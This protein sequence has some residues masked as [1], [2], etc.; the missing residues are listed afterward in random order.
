MRRLELYEDIGVE[1][2]VP[3]CGPFKYVMNALFTV[4]PLVRGEPVSWGELAD[5]VGLTKALTNV[6]EYETV[7]QMSNA[8]YSELR[9]AT[10]P[11]SIEPLERP[12]E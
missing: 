4:G 12:D 9:S 7:M 5:F 1:P 11:L 6:W 10:N 3:D 8:F 2:S